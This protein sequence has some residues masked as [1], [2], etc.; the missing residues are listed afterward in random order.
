MD[1]TEAQV[2]PFPMGNQLII[3]RRHPSFSPDRLDLRTI[4]NGSLLAISFKFF[5]GDS[6]NRIWSLFSVISPAGKGFMKA[7]IIN[8]CAE[9]ESKKS[10]EELDIEFPRAGEIC[11][12]LGSRNV[13]FGRSPGPSVKEEPNFLIKGWRLIFAVNSEPNRNFHWVFGDPMDFW[14]IIN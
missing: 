7:R 9:G 13:I 11:R 10:A 8:F 2:I 6:K 5:D 1:A 14:L 12:I 3:P 4:T